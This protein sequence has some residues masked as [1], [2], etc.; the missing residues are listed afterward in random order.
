M[1]N[2]IKLDFNSVNDI[3]SKPENLKFKFRTERE[4]A[5]IRFLFTMSLIREI[6]NEK[7]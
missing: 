6:L 3:I 7:S 4:I 5:A 2:V 1:S